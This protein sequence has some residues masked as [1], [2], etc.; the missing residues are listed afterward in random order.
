MRFLRLG[1]VLGTAA[2]LVTAWSFVQ[3]TIP[4]GD[5]ANSVPSS[6]TYYVSPRGHDAAD[7]TSRATAW[8]TLTRASKATLRPGDRLLFEGGYQYSGHLRLGP[9]DG[10][11][12]RDPVLVSSY[13]QGHATISSPASGIVVFDTGGIIIRGLVM[14]GQAAMSPADSGIQ[15]YSDRARG[16][17]RHVVIDN[18]DISGFGFGIA[19]GAVHDGAGFSNVR[20]TRS[21]LH[22]NLNAGLVSYGPDYDPKAPGYAHH[23]I[24]VSDVR[25]FNNFGDPANV[26]RNTGSGIEL[27]SVWTATVVHS[28]AYNN[29]GKGGAIR[30]GPIGIWAFDSTGVLFAHDVSHD[31]TSAT[32]HD[33]GGFGLDRETSDSVMQYNLSYHNH[34]A[35]FLLYS[36]LNAPAPQV[37]N[38]VRF[39]VSYGDAVGDHH[40]YGAMT[41]GGWVKNGTFYQNTI[42]LTRDNKQPV[43]KLTGI[44]HHVRMFNNILVAA[45]GPVVEVVPPL[46][47][48]LAQT[49][50][51]ANVL[52]AGNDYLAT[53]GPLFVQWG[54]H[55]EY[56]SI[57]AWRAATNEEQVGGRS[58]GLTVPPLFVGPLS[59][60]RGG[61]AFAL[62]KS[63]PLIGAGL[64]LLAL[65]GIQPGPVD[66][67]GMPGVV[68]KPN[69]G[70]Q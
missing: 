57:D 6:V 13:G 12:P 7:G 58:T 65:F 63:S 44:L 21:S 49:M 59:G 4:I 3:P 36:A 56:F 32:V 70:A 48:D 18:V 27:G 26:T 40:V 24:Y 34:G 67:S 9:A 28:Q 54:I 55:V 45:S 15:M 47:K 42:V 51:T 62:R 30:E 17:L 37:G 11:N 61:A 64:N 31:N 2:G 25:A 23:G 41:A 33:G 43:V 10:G 38:T 22:D 1:A 35:G 19:I 5:A 46:N 69:V 52:L 60:P 16:M 66:Y 29:G 20:V 50:T 53:A 8:R 39:N 14:V 68:T